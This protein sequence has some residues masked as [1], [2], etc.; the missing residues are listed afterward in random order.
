MTMAWTTFKEL[1]EGFKLRYWDGGF[2]N[3]PGVY[4]ETPGP[5]AVRMEIYYSSGESERARPTVA[6]SGSQ[7]VPNAVKKEVVSHF[8]SGYEEVACITVGRWA[9]THAIRRGIRRVYVTCSY[10]CVSD[11]PIQYYDGRV[12]YNTPEAIPAYVKRAVQ[13]AFSMPLSEAAALA[14]ASA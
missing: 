3:K 2:G 11:E 14:G 6:F 9:L 13:K 7:Q 12:A 5:D 1:S 8:H 4:L 10:R